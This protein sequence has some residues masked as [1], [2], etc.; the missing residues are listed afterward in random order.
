MD[1][2]LNEYYKDNAKKLHMVADK[3]LKKFG[4]LSEK[5]YQDFYSIANEVFVDVLKRYDNTRPFDTFLYSCLCNRFKSEITAR[6]RTKRILNAN[7]ISIDT[8]IKDGSDTTIGDMIQDDFNLENEIFGEEEQYTD[9]MLQYLSQLSH[10][11]KQVLNCIA[12]GYK[13]QE[14]I[15]KLHITKKQ[16]TD[17]YNAIYSYRNTQLLI[18]LL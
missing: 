15:D 10:L 17:C 14:I 3:I 9:N 18:S 1:Q 11:Q 8:P 2:I 16:Y 5:D 12:S 13:V 4:G 6:H 7:C